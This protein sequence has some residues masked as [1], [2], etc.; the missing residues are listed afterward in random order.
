M[1][2]DLLNKEDRTLK[3]VLIGCIFIYVITLGYSFYIN[4]QEQDMNAVGMSAL[5]IITPLIV[6]VL[7]RLLHLKPVYEIYIISTIFTYFASLMGSGLH[8][9]SYMGFDKALHFSSGWLFTTIA[10]ILYFYIVRHPSIQDQKE[11]RIFIIFINTV[12]MSV[13]V[14]W[15][16]F[17][18]AMLVFFN[19]DGINHYSQGVHDSMQDMLCATFA[20]LL[21]TV[22]II[23]YIKKG[24]SNFFINIYEKFYQRNI[25]DE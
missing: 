17:E 15:E 22:F 5:A 24:K 14:I 19:N 21:L 16:F 1:T 9:Y 10:I 11:Y 2:K 6:P 13:A 25:G 3:K 8:W 7:F 4:L 18:Y 20:G 23:R 12:N